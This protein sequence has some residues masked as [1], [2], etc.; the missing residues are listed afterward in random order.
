MKTAAGVGQAVCS[1][2]KYIWA[3]TVSQLQCVQ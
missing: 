2:S 3:E 1:V